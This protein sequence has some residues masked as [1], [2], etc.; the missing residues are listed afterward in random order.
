MRSGTTV[1]PAATG[2]GASSARRQQWTNSCHLAP[3]EQVQASGATGAVGPG[4][5]TTV[6]TPGRQTGRR[7]CRNWPRMG[8]DVLQARRGPRT[9]LSYADGPAAGPR[10]RHAALVRPRQPE[11]HLHRMAGGHARQ[12]GSSGG[13]RRTRASPSATDQAVVFCLLCA[14]GDDTPSFTRH[15]PR[16]P[17]RRAA[18]TGEVFRPP[19]RK[20][21]TARD[22]DVGWPA[23]REGCL[24]QG[25]WQIDLS[26]A[27]SRAA[28]ASPQGTALAR[29]R[30]PRTIAGGSLGGDPSGARGHCFWSGRAQAAREVDTRALAS[31]PG[32]AEQ[33]RVPPLRRFHV[34]ATKRPKLRPRVR[35]QRR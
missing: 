26:L 18:V 11:L 16:G 6:P 25:S 3:G 10:D 31:S 19:H 23:A 5:L 2:A 29:L 1:I 27:R 4:W 14:P 17:H 35:W 20:P 12:R 9:I 33:G 8:R 30:S 28:G 13:L 21:A 32:R 24:R 15:Q 34:D 22:S 7:Q